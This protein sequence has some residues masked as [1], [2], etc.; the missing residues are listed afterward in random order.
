MKFYFQ[1]WKLFLNKKKLLHWSKIWKMTYIHTT[2]SR[3]FYQ[4]KS[5]EGWGPWFGRVTNVVTFRPT[6]G[7]TTRGFVLWWCFTYNV[8]SLRVIWI[9][10]WK[11]GQYASFIL[12]LH[13][14][15][16]TFANIWSSWDL[17]VVM[18][19]WIMILIWI[20]T[21]NLVGFVYILHI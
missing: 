17:T 20:Y 4:Y 3:T 6:S 18:F 14:F 11:F 10:L 8:F 16:G 5:K 9:G 1:Q 2:L 15:L 13:P 19:F 21:W 7:S 12:N